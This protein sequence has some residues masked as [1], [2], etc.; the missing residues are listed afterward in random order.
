M[1]FYRLTLQQILTNIM[2]DMK[3]LN[4]ILFFSTAIAF[5]S[6]CLTST[7]SYLNLSYQAVESMASKQKTHF[8]IVLIDSS[9]NIE[10][11]KERIENAHIKQSTLW[12]FV[13]ISLPSNIWYT[14]LIGSNKTPFTLVFNADGKLQNIVYGISKY[15]IHSIKSSIDSIGDIFLQDFGLFENSIL[16]KSDSLHETLNDI[17]DVKKEYPNLS[18]DTYDLLVRTIH[19][20][21]HPYNTFLKIYYDKEIAQVSSQ[22]LLLKEWVKKYSVPPFSIIYQE[23]LSKVTSILQNEE[24]IQ[25]LLQPTAENYSCSLVDTLHFSVKAINLG[26][27]TIHIQSIEPSCNCV[28]LSN[29]HWNRDIRPHQ[30][31]E[32]DFIFI[33]EE[34]GIVYR[35]ITFISDTN[36]PASSVG[37]TIQVN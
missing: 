20:M 18:S 4:F 24:E 32:Y 16:T 23:P 6:G 2:T 29:V 33:P 1:L 27:D 22:N 36:I 15:A 30:F 19:S 12:N 10:Q 26:T 9:V 34:K 8:C 31:V 25:M 13:D 21:E 17:I 37:I 14:H 11:Y 28:V 3:K 35:E 5:L 7:E